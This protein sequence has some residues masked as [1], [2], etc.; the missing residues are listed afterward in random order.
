MW[1]SCPALQTELLD[2]LGAGTTT[3]RD[4]AGLD[5]V[6]TQ[7]L[8]AVIRKSDTGAQATEAVRDYALNQMRDGNAKPDNTT[9]VVVRV[10]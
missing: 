7:H 10:K 9:V 2:N 4:L 3:F 5:V 1:G 8:G 6:T